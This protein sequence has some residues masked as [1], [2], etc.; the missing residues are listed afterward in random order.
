VVGS[1]SDN[2]RRLKRKSILGQLVVLGLGIQLLFLG[3]FANVPLPTATRGNLERFAHTLANRE[4]PQLPAAWQSAINERFP[5]LRTAREPARFTPYVPL[6]PLSVL[7]GYVLGVPLGF[8]AGVAYCVLGLIGPA[9]GVLPLAAGGGSD[10]YRQAGFGYLLGIVLSCW[11]AGRVTCQRRTSL[12]Q[13]L[14]ALGGVLMVHAVGLLYLVGSSLVVLLCQ[15][16]EA[17]LAWQPWLA[18]QIRNLS[19]YPLPWDCLLSILAVGVG[20]PLR[21]LVGLL[22]APDMSAK[23]KPGVA[24]QLEQAG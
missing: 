11:F 2:L 19:W 6:V 14:A 13:M 7:V 10:Y 21:W 4:L 23:T 16:D 17:Y 22:T 5:A 15:G 12:A 1:F 24:N 9:F 20:A 18:E 8:F 3:S